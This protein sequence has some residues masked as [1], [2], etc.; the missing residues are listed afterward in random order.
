MEAHLTEVMT[1]PVAENPQGGL[2]EEAALDLLQFLQKVDGMVLGPGLGTHPTTI[3]CVHKLLQ[4]TLVPV[5]L[6]ADGLNSLEG[7]L[8][9]LRDCAAPVIMTPHPGEMARLLGRDTATVQAQRLEI[10]HELVRRFQGYAV[11]KGAHTVIYAPDGRCW[12]NPTGNPAMATAGTGDVLA[13][14]IGALLCQG[15]LPLHAAQ[16]GVYLHGLAGDRVQDRLGQRGLIASD[17][18]EELPYTIQA[19]QNGQ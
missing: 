15:M 17:I 18:L 12:I 16:C 7:A 8:D 6:D 1:L 19:V 11:L 9:V 2:A 3:A 5:V 4:H 14:V 10:A 13:G